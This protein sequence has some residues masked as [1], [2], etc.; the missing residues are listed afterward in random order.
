MLFRSEPLRVGDLLKSLEMQS[1]T[2]KLMCG[3][4]PLEWGKAPVRVE[5]NR[6]TYLEIQPGVKFV[7][8][9]EYNAAQ[10]N[11]ERLLSEIDRQNTALEKLEELA[12]EYRA[13]AA[14]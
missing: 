8:Q 6:V 11:I 7:T 4:I 2:D 5:H 12:S 10:A 14:V 9:E 1:H 3:G 13:G